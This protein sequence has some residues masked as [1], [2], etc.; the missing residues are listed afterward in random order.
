MEISDNQIIQEAIRLIES[1]VTVTFP[2]NGRSMLPFIIGGQ[3]S[4][5]LTRPVSVKV[6][7]VV[8]AY[9]NGTHFVV[10]RIERIKGDMVTLM[11]DGNL[12]IRERCT[13]ADVKAFA[14]H[15]IDASGKKRDLYTPVRRFAAK[16]W[17]LLR[18]FRKYLLFIYRKTHK[19]IPL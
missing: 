6:G 3:E 18:P 10:H 1:G 19:G 13:L 7:D 11:G 14:S 12:C 5:V 4:L 9:A 17:V 16:L 2:V 8:L 15:A